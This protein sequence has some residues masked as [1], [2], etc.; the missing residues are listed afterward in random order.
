MFLLFIFDEGNFYS[1]EPEKNLLLDVIYALEPCVNSVSELNATKKN[2]YYLQFRNYFKLL[3]RCSAA[4]NMSFFY[5]FLFIYLPRFLHFITYNSD[6]AG[7][8]HTYF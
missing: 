4:F 1:I 5:H 6:E 7:R 8:N 3:L 2:P